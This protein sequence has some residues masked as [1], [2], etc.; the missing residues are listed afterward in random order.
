MSITTEVS[1]DQQDWAPYE[2]GKTRIEEYQYIR[3]IDTADRS[4]SRR[5]IEVWLNEKSRVGGTRIEYT[6]D[7]GFSWMVFRRGRADD[8]ARLFTLLQNKGYSVRAMTLTENSTYVPGQLESILNTQP[9]MGN[10]MQTL[11]NGQP[12]IKT[13]TERR[14]VIQ[15]Q[16][17]VFHIAKHVTNADLSVSAIDH[18]IPFSLSA[19]NSNEVIAHAMRGLSTAPI[20]EG[21]V[22]ELEPCQFFTANW[23]R[24]LTAHRKV[25]EKPQD[26][27]WVE[28]ARVYD[29]QAYDMSGY[30]F[31]MSVLSDKFYVEN[32]TPLHASKIGSRWLIRTAD[33]SRFITNVNHNG[34]Y[35]RQTTIAPQ[36]I[37]QHSE[38]IWEAVTRAKE[39]LRQAIDQRDPQLIATYLFDCVDIKDKAV[40]EIEDLI[41][42]IQDARK[43]AIE[44]ISESDGRPS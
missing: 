34:G 43:T 14:W 20:Y 42:T 25:R 4:W 18:K 12:P 10:G 19:P 39:Q 1:H 31:A 22:Y 17:G 7:D 30:I 29:D 37:E 26:W 36:P 3:H 41:K 9:A 28:C 11:P 32:D 27:Y 44:L 5:Q 6:S 33:V 2:R 15:D 16:P 40:A 8:A 23:D 38:D 24:V 13:K 35:A 21:H